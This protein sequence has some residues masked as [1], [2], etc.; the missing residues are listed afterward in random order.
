MRGKVFAISSAIWGFTRRWLQSATAE[1]R[2]SGWLPLWRPSRPAA[3]PPVPPG[4]RWCRDTRAIPTD[5]TDR[6]ERRN[7]Q[8][9]CSCSAVFK[10]KTKKKRSTEFER[11]IW[12]FVVFFLT[13]RMDPVQSPTRLISPS[14]ET[15]RRWYPNRRKKKMFW[16]I[17][18]LFMIIVSNENNY[19]NRSSSRPT[20]FLSLISVIS[21]ASIPSCFRVEWNELWKLI[22]LAIR[23]M[24][25]ITQ[26]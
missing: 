6:H 23:M 24:K 17:N 1:W 4:P 2:R 12:S 14:S 18:K 19:L 9:L 20:T 3:M 25:E 13:S 26:R 10:N 11:P 8:C 7:V 16:C 15:A 22:A 21:A 5:I